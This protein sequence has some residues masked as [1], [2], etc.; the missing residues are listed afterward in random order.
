MRG[1]CV[2]V[3]H[4][5]NELLLSSCYISKLF[6]R[7]SFSTLM[8]QHALLCRT[9]MQRDPFCVTWICC[10]PVTLQG[11][12]LKV[13]HDSSC[14]LRLWPRSSSICLCYL[15]HALFQCL[16]LIFSLCVSVADMKELNISIS[17]VLHCKVAGRPWKKQ[18]RQRR[19]TPRKEEG[20]VKAEQF[21]KYRLEPVWGNKERP[22]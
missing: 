1:V 2:L 12:S 4:C 20:S 14:P 5:S 10:G 13:I 11:S 17:D 18:Q 7:K 22:R 9:V 21:W 16:F 8:E 19:T 3:E 15:T 6:H